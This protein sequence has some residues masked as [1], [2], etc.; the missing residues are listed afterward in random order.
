MDIFFLIPN[1]LDIVSI[2]ITIAV[3]TIHISF[4]FSSII[5]DLIVSENNAENG[6]NLYQNGGLEGM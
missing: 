3:N 4:N 6:F 1:V 5:P 2:N